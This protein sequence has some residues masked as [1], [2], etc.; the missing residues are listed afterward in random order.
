M[1]KCR[2]RKVKGLVVQ[3]DAFLRGVIRLAR[4]TGEDALSGSASKL[5]CIMHAVSVSGA[6]TR[7]VLGKVE[8]V[9]RPDHVPS[10]YCK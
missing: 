1:M 6:K 10:C 4:A 2:Y 3:T 7:L 9:H 8:L 5:T